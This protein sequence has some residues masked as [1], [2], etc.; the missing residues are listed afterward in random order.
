VI[1]FFQNFLIFSSLPMIASIFVVINRSSK[2]PKL[3][4][5][6]RQIIFSFNGRAFLGIIF[7]YLFSSLTL[8]QAA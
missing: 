1:N 3:G 5:T 2:H 4:S 8:S 7:C 6:F